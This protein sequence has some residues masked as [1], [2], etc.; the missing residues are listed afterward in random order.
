MIA[1]VFGRYRS[2]AFILY[3]DMFDLVCTSSNSKLQWIEPNGLNSALVKALILKATFQSPKSLQES[4][5]VWPH[6]D[7]C[8]KEAKTRNTRA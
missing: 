3:F 6:F 2:L 5:R 8:A 7:V 1:T 4:T